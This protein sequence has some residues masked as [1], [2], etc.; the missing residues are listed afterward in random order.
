MAVRTCKGMILDDV[1]NL[2]QLEEAKLLVKEAIAAG[3]FNDLGSGSNVDL[4]VITKDAV[5]HCR[6]FETLNIK[7]AR[8]VART[9]RR[10]FYRRFCEFSV[11]SMNRYFQAR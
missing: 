6:P 11:V 8:Q 5:E 3:I 4:C 1:L 2:I 9:S 10:S 7:G